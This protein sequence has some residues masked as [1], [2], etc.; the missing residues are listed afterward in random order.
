MEA[1]Q[2]ED[3]ACAT[4]PAA[5]TRSGYIFRGWTLNG[6]AYDFSTPVTSD[7]TLT[8]KWER[9]DSG[10]VDPDSDSDSGAD[11]GKKKLL[12]GTGD[13]SALAMAASAAAGI[14]AAAAGFT[15][16]RRKN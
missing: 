10:K 8:A 15:K 12:P 16:R 7:I 14:T 2:V 5:P 13:A 6:A 9:E 3:G 1:Q 4:E 11:S